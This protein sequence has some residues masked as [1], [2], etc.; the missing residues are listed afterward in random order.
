M[1]IAVIGAKGLPPKQGGI[2]Y[3]CAELYPRMVAQGHTVDLFARSSYVESSVWNR[4]HFKGVRVI[5]LPSPKSGGWDAMISSALGAI[6]TTGMQ[7]DII[8]FHALGPALFSWVPRLMSP[9]KVVVT[10]HGLD[11]QRAKWGKIA[12]HSILLGEKAA[13]A[14]AHEMI[15]VSESLRSYFSKTYGRDFPYISNAPTAYPPSDHNFNWGTSLE[16]EQKRYIV[17]LGRLVPEKRPDLLIQAFQAVRNTGWKLVLVG[18]HDSSYFHTQLLELAANQPDVIFTGELTGSRLAEI[19]RGSGMCVLPSDLE[20]LPMAM[21]EA[22]EEGIPIVASDIPPHR[23]LLSDDR[24]ILFR[25]GN[26]NSC[27]QKLDWAIRHPEVLK[28][29]AQRAQAYVRLNH[30]WDQIAAASLKLYEAILDQ[31]YKAFPSPQISVHSNK[32]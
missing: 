32:S 19:V 22:M 25:S 16:L 5:S 11:W 2:E 28:M 21:L 14:C 24:G 31:P 7:Y 26:L 8:H 17:F 30:N 23:Q 6:L 29:M 10:C 1:K 27:I 15:V 12:G 4:S 3:H 20:G 13:V 18:S 9:A